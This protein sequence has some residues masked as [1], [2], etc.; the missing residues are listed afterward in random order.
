MNQ[1]LVLNTA[2]SQQW[3]AQLTSRPGPVLQASSVWRCCSLRHLTVNVCT[4][5]DHQHTLAL[6]DHFTLAA[7][8][9]NAHAMELLAG[10][11]ALDL[12]LQLQVTCW[13]AS[14]AHTSAQARCI[15]ALAQLHCYAESW[16]GSCSGS[17][18]AAP[19][20]CSVKELRL[21]PSPC[22]PSSCPLGNSQIFRRLSCLAPP[23]AGCC[24][25]GAAGCCRLAGQHPSGSL[26]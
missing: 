3:R 2:L 10:A 7:A 25:C 4:M 6:L 9:G 13:A 11:L 15:V 26:S 22:A 1:S 5:Q 14:C 24:R 19:C 12:R 8:A 20:R 23:V 17:S 18:A 21:P 16:P